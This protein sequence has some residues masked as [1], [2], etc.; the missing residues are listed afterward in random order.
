MGAFGDNTHSTNTIVDIIG[1]LL[2]S[3]FVYVE[4]RDKTPLTER[5]PMIIPHLKDDQFL[6]L[7]KALIDLKGMLPTI[8]AD[9]PPAFNFT[10]DQLEGGFD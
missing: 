4:D 9:D 5:G 8:S 2:E 10:L 3:R 1:Q 7:R 6:S